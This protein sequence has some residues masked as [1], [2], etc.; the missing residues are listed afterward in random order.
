M[1]KL[2]AR[3]PAPEERLARL[4]EVRR[5]ELE[6]HAARFAARIS[7]LEHREQLLRDARLSV[8]RLLRLGSTDLEQRELELA[9]LVGELT[10]REARLREQE[11]ELARR[12]AELGAVELRRAALERRERALEQREAELAAREAESAAGI[13]AERA[14]APPEPS[15]PAP[16]LLFV[17]GER[18]RLVEAVHPPL[19]RGDAVEVEG[20]RYVVARTGP[21]PLPGDARRCAYLVRAPGGAASPSGG[22]R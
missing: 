18:Y 20:A 14:S 4:L 12:R 11:A 7:D 3:G 2:L 22:S 17:P 16:V 9:Q 15:V 6:Q 5:R 8:E 13:P 19:S 10:E 21:S 1:R